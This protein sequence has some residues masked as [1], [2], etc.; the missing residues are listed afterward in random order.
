LTRE[1]SSQN[2]VGWN[3]HSCFIGVDS[4]VAK[5]AVTPIQFIYFCGRRVN[6][7]G[8]DRL[9]PE[10]S[11]S[12]SKTAY[13]SEEVD[14]FECFNIVLRHTKSLTG[15]SDF[16]FKLIKNAAVLPKLDPWLKT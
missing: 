3:V 8:V 5:G 12:S 15:T 6:L 16:D 14:E 7:N 10:G 4:N 11:Q 1:A 9:S 2:V 13:A